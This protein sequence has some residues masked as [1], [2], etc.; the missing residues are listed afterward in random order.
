L[1]ANSKTSWRT[2]SKP[3]LKK[4]SGRISFYLLETVFPCDDLQDSSIFL[5]LQKCMYNFLSGPNNLFFIGNHLQ[6]YGLEDCPMLSLLYNN[7]KPK[8]QKAL[9][10]Y[11]QGG[12]GEVRYYLEKSYYPCSPDRLM[13]CNSYVTDS[14]TDLGAIFTQDYFREEE[15]FEAKEDKSF[16]IKIGN[17]VVINKYSDEH[18]AQLEKVSVLFS[19]SALKKDIL[20]SFKSYL[21]RTPEYDQYARDIALNKKIAKYEREYGTVFSE[22]YYSKI[23]D[24]SVIDAKRRGCNRIPTSLC[25]MSQSKMYCETMDGKCKVKRNAKVSRKKNKCKVLNKE[26]CELKRYCLWIA[27][28]PN[29][30]IDGNYDSL[31]GKCGPLP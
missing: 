22:D 10:L 7:L 31:L 11:T 8:F 3:D 24:L 19:G 28:T 15:K 26:E 5:L 14:L 2:F 29:D 18:I 16:Q 12:T 6:A 21:P 17:G 1:Q 13:E 4:V 30:S 20:R 9:Q 23:L 25:G 27:N